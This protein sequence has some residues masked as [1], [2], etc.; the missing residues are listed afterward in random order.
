ME[1]SK[2][3]KQRHLLGWWQRK[4]SGPQSPGK[5]SVK[6]RDWWAGGCTTLENSNR[7]NLDKEGVNALA[8][9]TNNT[10][11]GAKANT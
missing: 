5:I 6:M 4:I 9:F 1:L 7:D 2:G 11:N 3:I 8:V 10:G